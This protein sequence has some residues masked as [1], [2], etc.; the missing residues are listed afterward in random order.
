MKILAF[1][2]LHRSAKFARRI[3]EAAENADLVIGAG[4]YATKQH[5]LA[6]I[7]GLLKTIKAPTFLVPGNHED[8]ADLRA[9]CSNWPNA[10]VLH[11]EVVSFQGLN[12]F[13]LGYE[14]PQS[15]TASWNRFMSERQAAAILERMSENKK[16]CDI[17]VSHAPP[18]GIADRQADGRHDGSRALLDFITSKQP[19]LHLCGHIHNDWGA[20]GR[21]GT[22]LVQNLGP[23]ANWF[24]MQAGMV[25]ALEPAA[26]RLCIA[27]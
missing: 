16:A 20:S 17:L 3:V 14:I 25:K 8:C 1:S 10:K 2:D 15:T 21:V 26:T 5:G 18:Y 4:D 27:M 6:D 22:C 9:E 24:D 23:T 12:I 13:G 7:I 19:S 11:G